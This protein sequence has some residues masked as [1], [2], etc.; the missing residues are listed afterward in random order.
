M[1]LIGN[2]GVRKGARRAGEGPAMRAEATRGTGATGR[3]RRGAA[4]G[5]PSVLAPA[6]LPLPGR[7]DDPDRLAALAE[8]GLLASGPDERLDRLSRLA[9][10]ASGAPRAAISLVDALG[11]VFVG[12]HGMPP[13]APSRTGIAES[14]CRHVVEGGRPIVLPD[15]A[16]EPGLALPAGPVRAYLGVPL[17]TARGHVLGAFCLMDV[18]PRAWTVED[19]ATLGEFADA[20]MAEIALR[21]EREARERAEAGLREKQALIDVAMEASG[22]VGTWA[23]DGDRV[24]LDRHAAR[25]FGVGGP[26]ALTL[27]AFVD[28]IHPDDRARVVASAAGTAEGEGFVEE[29]RLAAGVDATGTARA[30]AWVEARGKRVA[31]PDGG[32]RLVGV[33]TDVTQA[34][35]AAQRQAD[36]SAE[37]GH[38]MKNLMATV[39]AIVFQTMRESEDMAGAAVAVTE[40]LAALGRSHDLLLAKGWGEAGIGETVDQVTGYFG[41]NRFDVSGPEVDLPPRAALALSMALHELATNAVKYGALSVPPG[42]VGIAWR[43]DGCGLVIRWLETGGPAV[44][45]P[46]RR[47]LGTRLLDRVLSAEMHGRTH[48]AYDPAGL[49]CLIEG[50][51][52]AMRREHRAAAGR[53]A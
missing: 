7:L 3:R 22:R 8:T 23:W 35:D 39:Q 19:R 33:V 5:V 49:E 20:A 29:V 31:G 11:Q 45:P 44:A 17:A 18:R 32:A 46:V 34:H 47:G 21:A 40:R 41:R 48:V 25:L 28:R 50:D 38:R 52:D 1:F 12:S 6:A 14:V 2:A 4:A 42:R 30:G 43:L 10:R 27:H 51:L 24:A 15:L 37:L 36:L 53:G 13:D 26:G 16:D 9:A